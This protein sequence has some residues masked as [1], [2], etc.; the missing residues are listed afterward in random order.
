MGATLKKEVPLKSISPIIKTMSNMIDPQK[1]E[2]SVLK[3]FHTGSGKYA[4][5]YDSAAPEGHSFQ[6]RRQRVLEMIASRGVAKGRAM[7]IGCGPGVMVG[8]LL[9]LGYEVQGVDIA[10]GMI[11]ECRKQFG[12]C[13]KASF[14]VGRIE[15]MD[16]PTSHFDLI[17][18]SGVVEYLVDDNAGIA[19]LF[20]VLKPGGTL[21]VTCPNFFS[22][23]RRWSSFYWGI[24]NV[25]KKA[26]GRPIYGEMHHREYK[27]GNYCRLIEQ[28]GFNVSDVCYYNF[29]V[30][31][32]PLDRWFLKGAIE[33]SRKL[34]TNCRSVLRWMGTGFIISAQK[35]QGAQG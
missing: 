17:V 22:P 12:N 24:K 33:L 35:H 15:K 28:H 19:E 6:I 20:R 31:P 32:E 13:P 34:E 23:W 29:K 18:C 30:V 27:S 21:I 5:R 2:A 1:Q 16:F 3:T 9:D 14:S 10:E 26:I 25:I 11:E 4:A 7:D 8:Q